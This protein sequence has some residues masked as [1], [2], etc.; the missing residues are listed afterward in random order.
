MYRFVPDAAWTEPRKAGLY[1]FDRGNPLRYL[2]PDGRDDQLAIAAEGHLGWG[3]FGMSCAAVRQQTRDLPRKV[4][5]KDSVKLAVDVASL[6]DQ[7]P[8][9]DI[10]SAAI[11][12]AEGDWEGAGLSVLAA[13]AT[14]TVV[15]DEVV[16]GIKISRDAEHGAELAKA[17]VDASYMAGKAPTV[18]K[19]PSGKRVED[20][21]KA[22]K[23][24]V[25]KAS[26]DA[27]GGQA[28]CAGCGTPVQRVK[29]QKGVP[30]PENAGQVHHD[31]PIEAGGTRET[32]V[33][34]LFC[35][36]CHRAKSVAPGSSSGTPQ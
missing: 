17:T 20:F 3:C 29:S 8:V 28:V 1:Q 18:A 31:P 21:T 7:T 35:A 22:Q 33:P 25:W 15:G 2:D 16:E 19:T 6:I 10:A 14:V 32:S 34:V 13:V 5:D 24:G 30:T 9:S 27:N 23:N 4:I 36:P 26:A 11:S 12:V